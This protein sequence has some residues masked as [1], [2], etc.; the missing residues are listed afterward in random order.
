MNRKLEKAQ[1]Q[2]KK[3]KQKRMSVENVLFHFALKRLYFKCI[4]FTKA[5]K[6]CYLQ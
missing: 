4:I 1:Q 2:Q 5:E 6:L 3:N